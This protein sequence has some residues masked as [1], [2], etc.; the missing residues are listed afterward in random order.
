M[1][2]YM[3]TLQ[4]SWNRHEF[5]TLIFVKWL[6]TQLNELLELK[7]GNGGWV[8]V[9]MWETSICCKWQVKHWYMRYICLFFCFLYKIDDFC[10]SWYVFVIVNIDGIAQS[11]HLF[12]TWFF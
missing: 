10:Q 4:L 6:F 2:S 9:D 1:C 8:V 12:R 3:E 5:D 11:L 7:G